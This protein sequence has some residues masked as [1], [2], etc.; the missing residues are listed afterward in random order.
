LPEAYTNI[1]M[2]A[3]R[4]PLTERP[5]SGARLSARPLETFVRILLPLGVGIAIGIGIDSDRG[6]FGT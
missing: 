6:M 5:V 4:R 1:R 3:N 2:D